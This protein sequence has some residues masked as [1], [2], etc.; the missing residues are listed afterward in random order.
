M[1]VIFECVVCVSVVGVCV[2]VGACVESRLVGRDAMLVGRDAMLP[3]GL[4][5][6]FHPS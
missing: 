2:F 5:R 3:H 4:L 6:G 1:C